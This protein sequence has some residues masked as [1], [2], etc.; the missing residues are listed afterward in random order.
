MHSSVK[1]TK[2]STQSTRT[3][4][5]RTTE[6]IKRLALDE[7]G[8]IQKWKIGLS[9][10]VGVF[11]LFAGFSEFALIFSCTMMMRYR[12]VIFA[13]FSACLFAY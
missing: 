13:Q 7:A 2:P 4:L 5:G 1:K 8:S 12:L 10:S 3:E 6:N 9:V 11:V